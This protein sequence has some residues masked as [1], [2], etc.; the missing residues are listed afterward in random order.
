MATIR[1]SC[2]DCGDVELTTADV[3]VRVCDDTNAGTYAF[4]CPHCRMM[5]VKPA[6][7]RTVDLLVASGVAFTTW[8]LP[9]ELSEVHH[10]EPITHDDLLDFHHLLQD[11]T[12]LEQEL[13]N[14]TG[15]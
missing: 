5:V 14:F 9:A 13:A 1:A 10:G 12:R 6:E 2:P 11:D 3:T 8:R 7:T 4:R 15:R